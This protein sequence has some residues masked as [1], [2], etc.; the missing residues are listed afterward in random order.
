MQ[1]MVDQGERPYYIRV[2]TRLCMCCTLVLIMLSSRGYTSGCN[3]IRGQCQMW[4]CQGFTLAMMWP[5]LSVTISLTVI[6]HAIQAV[7]A[8]AFLMPSAW[9]ASACLLSIHA[10]GGSHSTQHVVN[11]LCGSSVSTKDNQQPSSQ[12]RS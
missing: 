5:H 10:A 7:S 1:K 2:L 9:A 11:K 4:C 12:H 8:S 6:A 3:A